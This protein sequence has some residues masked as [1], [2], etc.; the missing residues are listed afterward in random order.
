LHDIGQVVVS[1]LEQIAQFLEHL[2]RALRERHG[3]RWWDVFG[4]PPIWGGQAT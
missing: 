2:A 3:P 4:L 1:W